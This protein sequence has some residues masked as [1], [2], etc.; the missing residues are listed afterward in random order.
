MVVVKIHQLKDGISLEQQHFT[1]AFLDQYRMSNCKPVVTPLMPNEHLSPATSDEIQALKKLNTNYRSAIGSINYLSTATRPD[2][3]CA[4]ITISKYLE[5]AGLRH[6]QAFLHVLKYFNGSR[7][8]V[9]YYPRRKSNGI[10]AFS[11][12]YWGNCQVTRHSTTG[13][14]TC[15]VPLLKAYLFLFQKT[16][17]QTA[18]TF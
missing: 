3:L 14:L 7:N 9:L 15:L 13:Y 10:T 4:V 18:S 17:Y 8:K 5:S 12:A 11:N 1:E 16:L 6:W 2:L